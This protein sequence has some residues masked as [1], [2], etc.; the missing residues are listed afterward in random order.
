MAPKTAQNVSEDVRNVPT[1]IPQN[2]PV[3]D[4]DSTSTQPTNNVYP[5]TQSAVI[6]STQLIIALVAFEGIN[7][8]AIPA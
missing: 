5:A 3:A 1:T 4:T 2:A 8:S 6:A 7:L